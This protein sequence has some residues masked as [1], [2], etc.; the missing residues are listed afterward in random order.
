VALLHKNW[1][2]LAALAI[3]VALVVGAYLLAFG[4]TLAP[5]AEAT[6]ETE[7]LKAITIKDSDGD[8]L[9]D[10][11]ELLYRTDPHT[12]DSRGLGMSDGEAV[13]KGLIV[14]PVSVDIAPPPA[15][16]QSAAELGLPSP[17]EGS[18]TDIF[19]KNFFVLY[20]SAK[21][22]VGRELTEDEVALLATKAIEGLAGSVTVNADLYTAADITVAGAGSEA[23]RAYASA[24]QAVL[25]T[26][27]TNYPKSE[28]EYLAEAVKGDA[29]ALEPIRKIATAYH[30]I[31]RGLVALP[32]PVE[33]RDAHLTLV[34][35]LAAIGNTTSD[36]GR[37]DTD[38]LTTLLAVAQYRAA[39]KKMINSFV[40]I[41]EV[42]KA[43]NVTFSESEAGESFVG[44]IS[45]LQATP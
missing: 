20:L 22:E 36:F 15:S 3:A 39:V 18:L 2:I 19:A 14:P 1:M 4:T 10:W 7:L 16:G 41:D 5:S 9:P 30:N 12:I 40:A 8:G 26:H 33:V 34:N 21:Q 23:L 28:V 31:A 17:S 37:Y 11:E 27:S 45:N 35:A 32:V 38:P 13:A 6:T 44:V 24:G 29:S 25:T 43:A 42:Y